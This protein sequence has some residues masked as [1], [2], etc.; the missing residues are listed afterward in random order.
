MR[1][2]LTTLEVM[3]AEEEQG[4]AVGVGLAL[5]KEM[6]EEVEMRGE[7]IR[8]EQG[9]EGI[10]WWRNGIKGWEWDGHVF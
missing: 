9:G 2:G 6:L 5:V 10:R 7:L 8:D 3:K 1:E 4:V